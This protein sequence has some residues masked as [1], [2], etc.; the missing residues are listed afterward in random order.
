MKPTPPKATAI[1][2]SSAV[3]GR[4]ASN[5]RERRGRPRFGFT[6][7]RPDVPHGR[8]SALSGRRLDDNWGSRQGPPSS[9]DIQ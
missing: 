8:G 3:D 1:R 6:A 2:L 5:L 9:R 7:G 4:V